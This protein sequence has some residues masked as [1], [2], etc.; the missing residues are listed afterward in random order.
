MLEIY[1]KF[2]NDKNRLIRLEAY[3]Q[4]GPFVF[5]L[6]NNVPDIVI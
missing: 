2:L 4:I 3:K 1:V 6:K 5:C